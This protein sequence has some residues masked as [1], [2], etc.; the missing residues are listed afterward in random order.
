MPRRKRPNIE[1]M[2]L[3]EGWRTF[4]FWL[5]S[6]R[7]KKRLTQQQAAKAVGVSKRQWIRYEMGSRVQLKRLR[8]IAE[9]LN[10]S[11]RRVLYLAGYKTSP[12]L[13][14]TSCRLR[15]I[16]DMLVVGSL[17]IALAEFLWLYDQIRP[18]DRGPRSD[19][20]GVTAPN[21]ANAIIFLDRLPNWLLDDILKATQ[22]R[23]SRSREKS[24]IHPRVMNSIRKECIEALRNV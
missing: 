9:A 22:E 23:T 12:K 18:T 8:P 5:E 20:N 14:D 10:I 7:S 11:Y 2:V 15:R 19:F 6:E 24:E 21:F 17:D 3:L 16:H 1:K 4:G 13:N